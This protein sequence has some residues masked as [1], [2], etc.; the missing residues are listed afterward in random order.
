M[1]VWM[2][3]LDNRV[4]HSSENSHILLFA[5]NRDQCRECCQQD[6]LSNITKKYPKAVLA[7]CTCK[8]GAYPQIQA[9]INSRA[10]KFHNLKIRYVNGLDPVIRLFDD[11]ENMVETLAINKWTT[12]QVEEYFQTHLIKE[13]TSYLVTNE[14]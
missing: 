11:A 9:F 13:D 4:I 6:D 14:L 7:V 12:D 8:F 2:P 5:I 10:A 3:A 1:R